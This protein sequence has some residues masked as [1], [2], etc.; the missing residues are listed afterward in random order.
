[1]IMK[2]GSS[3]KRLAYLFAKWTINDRYSWS[4]KYKYTI[5]TFFVL[6]SRIGK[7]S[8]IH[9]WNYP[10]VNHQCSLC[11]CENVGSRDSRETKVGLD[12]TW[13]IWEYLG[14]LW[15]VKG[16]KGMKGTNSDGERLLRTHSIRWT[17]TRYK[18]VLPRNI[19]ILTRGKVEMST[20][21]VC[22]QGNME[23][24]SNIKSGPYPCS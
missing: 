8:Y 5:Y 7:V 22:F 4:M 9:V 16:M 20:A 23:I 1:M 6:L 13:R 2:V 19:A 18:G 10:S 14:K 21:K 24:L 17:S 3:S 15:S 11:E 12:M